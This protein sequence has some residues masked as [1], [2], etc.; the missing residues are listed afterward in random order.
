MQEAVLSV[1]VALGDDLAYLLKRA[2]PDAL[3]PLVRRAVGQALPRLDPG[4]RY[5]IPYAG[6]FS[7]RVAADLLAF[8]RNQG[9]SGGLLVVDDDALRTIFFRE[10]RVVGGE[11]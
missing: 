5:R 8:G 9:L 11:S 4:Y 3:D 7:N 1:S 6:H 2:L 10:G